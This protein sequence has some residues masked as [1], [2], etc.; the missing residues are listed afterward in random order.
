MRVLTRGAGNVL[1]G[2]EDD[3]HAVV[4]AHR[5]VQVVREQRARLEAD[6]EL[7][8]ERRVLDAAGDDTGVIVLG[9]HLVLHG[10][11]AAQHPAGDL[12]LEAAPPH[13]LLARRIERGRQPGAAIGRI[14]A[15]VGA[16]E[17]I[18]VGLVRREPAA[19]DD[20]G[21][22]VTDVL[23]VEA[24]ADRRGRADDAVAVEHYEL[25]VGEQLD[26]L[27]IVRGLEPL[28]VGE[29]RETD[30]LQFFELLGM[31]RPRVHHHAAAV[32]PPVGTNPW[33]GILTAGSSREQPTSAFTARRRCRRARRL[34]PA[35]GWAGGRRAPRR[36][37][38]CRRGY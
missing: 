1:R 6:P 31:F 10:A 16:V 18:A 19:L 12:A 32:E 20:V 4:V 15:D 7:H 30:A 29:R 17:P 25:A 24:Q 35:P 34:S 26:V 23:E 21:E 27:A 2:V 5:I 37:G 9:G 3:E 11:V 38:R 33:P 13:Q 36:R 22:R 8:R 14:D 28:R